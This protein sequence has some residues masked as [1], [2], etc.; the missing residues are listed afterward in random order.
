MLFRTKHITLYLQCDSVELQFI[1]NDLPGNDFNELFRAVEKF[2]KSD[3]TDQLGRAP[4]FYYI[5]GL[6]ES[7]YKRL[8]P[9]QSVHLFHSSYCLHWRS[10]VPG[11]RDAY[12]NKDNIYITYTTTLAEVKQF[13]EQFHKDFSLFLKLRHEE[14]VYG[15]KMVLIFLGREDEDAC[16]GDLNK[17]FGL[18]ARSLQ[19]LVLKGLVE[20]QK[21]ESF[22][23]PVYGP[24][25]AEVKEVVMQS[26]L[27]SMD[28]I[29][30]FEANWDPF[31]DS[32]G[33]D[34]H[35]IAC[36]SLNIARGL[37]SVLKSLIASH[38]EEA[39][40]KHLEVEKTKYALIA[41]SLKK[42]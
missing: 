26:K 17:L 38:F 29:K 6:P 37:R 1:L 22:N 9:H 8:F 20:K 27:F 16:N 4:P 3:T 31:D 19:S 36:S 33:D 7:Y 32:E 14:L 13:Q 30:L 24:S 5:S 2:K 39:I 23:L 28:Q 35:D 25:V 15:G 12:L 18:V 11:G 41:T 34:V 10:Q 21:L 42:I 40:A